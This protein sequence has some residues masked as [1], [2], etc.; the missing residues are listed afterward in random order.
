MHPGV[1]V[2]ERFEIERIAASGG[3]GTVYRAHD[4]HTGHAVALKVLAAS[5]AGERARFLREVR[6]LA[7]LRH[8]AIVRYVAHGETPEHEP[9]LAMEWLD[10]ETLS[11]RLSRGHLSTEETL[12]VA[13]RIAEAL[14]AAHAREVVHRDVKPSNVLLVSGDLGAAKLIDFGVVRLARRDSVR[15]RTGVLVGT[16]QYMSPEQARGRAKIDARSDVFALGCVMFR[17]LTGRAPFTADDYLGILARLLIDDA[18]RVRTLRADV[19]HAVDELIAR[20]LT[21]DPAGRPADGAAALAEIADLSMTALVTQ[22]NKP[23]SAPSLPR[24]TLT[25]A[26]QALLSVVLARVTPQDEASS[27]HDHEVPGELTRLSRV[28]AP[29]GAHIER[30]RDGTILVTLVG[31]GSATDSAA[32]AAHCALAMRSIVS[33]A[34]I[35]LATGRGVV[36]GPATIGEVIDRAVRL[37]RA[38]D[39]APESTRVRGRLPIRIDDVTAGLLDQRFDVRGGGDAGLELAGVHDAPQHGRT[40]LGKHTPFVGRDRELSVLVGIFDECVSEPVARA[41]L[42]TAPAGMGKSRLLQ[43]LLHA[44]A[45]AATTHTLLVARGDPL[46]AGSPFGLIAPALRTSAGIRDGE[47]ASLQRDKLRQRVARGLGGADLQRVLE[48]LGELAGVPFPDD[49]S[50]QL[51]TARRDA[52]L[53]ADQMR[54]AWEDFLAAECDRQPVLVVLEDLHWGDAPSVQ[55][56][57]AA[58]RR[59]RDRPFMVVALARPEV[60]DA[61]PDLWRE[62]TVQPVPLPALGRR[63]AERLVREVLGADAAAPVL[64]RI[65][66]RA[67]GN[68]FYLEELIRAI[69]GGKGDELPGTVLAMVQARLATL[70]AE[71]RRVLRAASVFGEVFWEDAVGSLLDASV[72]VQAWLELLSERELVVARA[73]GRFPGRREYCFRHALVREAAYAMLTEAD[74]PRAHALAGAWLERVGERDA[75]LLADHYDR[76]GERVRAAEWYAR[77]AEQALEANDLDGVLARARAGEACGAAGEVLGRRL[78]AQALAHQWRGHWAQTDACARGALGMLPRGSRRWCVAAEEAIFAL[79]KL[80]EYAALDSFVD[81]LLEVTP[82]ED[83]RGAYAIALG[84]GS[85]F[86]VHATRFDR[87]QLVLER[88]AAVEQGL[89]GTDVGAAGQLDAIR[90]GH[91][92]YAGDAEGCLRLSQSAIQRFELAGDVRA[93]AMQLV[94]VGDS[95]KELGLYEQAEGPLREA[96]T[97]AS[98]MGLRVVAALAKLNLGALLGYRGA[99]DE[100]LAVGREAVDAF[101]VYGDHR[102]QIAA[103]AYFALVSI[104]AGKLDQAERIAREATTIPSR[105]PSTHAFALGVLAT[106][107]L[108]LGRAEEALE[109][110]REAVRTIDEGAVEEG[111]SM[112]RLAH[113]EALMATGDEEGARRAIAAARDRVLRRAEA[114]RDPATR[115]AYL[116]RVPPNARVMAR[117]S[118]WLGV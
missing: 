65:V 92:L 69:A 103:R 33:T 104:A 16:V 26:E 105:S 74:L 22:A 55:F 53:M 17:C 5:A 70:D 31:R 19:P 15:T 67:G 77:A 64:G 32:A 21:K 23:S 114:L 13:R 38:A 90:A 39:G 86:L 61:F 36:A 3:M 101:T 62:H 72:D 113:A 98:R 66:E 80:G 109:P 51:R 110:A 82:G 116:E 79:G 97:T 73:E 118:Q 7:E 45:R 24:A 71:A 76:G 108:A 34:P 91:S 85:W 57:D 99:T 111:E 58:L 54:R 6:V 10:G 48:F 75:A 96:I 52:M 37:M 47:P 60:H 1:R 112:I 44:L 29:Y 8:P 93:V 117:A 20:M 107:L 87:A 40:L 50:V 95:Y 59:L 2:A 89:A 49:E 41:A 28:L 35:V 115:R 46:R 81:S 63:A 14:A 42:V 78:L 4:R 18:V 106:A 88:I 56:V 100:A 43:E 94:F 30:F 12:V 27:D 83:A 11:Q 84:R 25:Q 9:W 102:L 68:A